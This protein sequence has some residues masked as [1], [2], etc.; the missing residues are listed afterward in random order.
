M[1]AT[2]SERRGCRERQNR[3]RS[4]RAESRERVEIGR[5]KIVS[6]LTDAVGLIDDHE[7]DRATGEQAPQVGGRQLLRRGEDELDG[8]APDPGP[9]P[10]DVSRRNGTIDLDGLQPELR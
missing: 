9:C 3:G 2:T 6:P 1:S 5:S 4:E 7:I 10:P 8:P